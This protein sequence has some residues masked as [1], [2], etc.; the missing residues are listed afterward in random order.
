MAW[1]HPIHPTANAYNIKRTLNIVQP[2]LMKR[3][4]M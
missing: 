4:P 2:T 1:D 3:K